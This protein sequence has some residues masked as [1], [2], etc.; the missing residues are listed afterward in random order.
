M[1]KELYAICYEEII[2]PQK[3]IAHIEYVH[4]ENMTHAKCVF[5]HMQPNYR[6]FRIVDAGLA[7]GHFCNFHGENRTA[8]IAQKHVIA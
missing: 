5:R 3:V 4:A 2:N 6:R 8:D 1:K 7:V